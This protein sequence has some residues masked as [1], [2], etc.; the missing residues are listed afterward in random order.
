MISICL[1]TF[2]RSEFIAEAIHSIQRQS[3]QDWELIIVDDCST[4][5][6]AELLKWYIN[7]DKRIKVYWNDKNEGIAFS[8]NEAV[9]YAKG[10]YIAVMDSDDVMHPDRLK[11][12]LKA[13]KGK[14]FVY[15]SYIICDQEGHAL[16]GGL[17]MPPTKLTI[18]GVLDGFTPPHVT[19]LARKELFL[20]HPYLV[21]HRVNDDLKL[22]LDLVKGGYKY[23]RI[24]EPLMMVRYHDT[25]ISKEKAK[26][27]K[28]V[29]D[30]LKKEYL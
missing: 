22:Q 27:I 7:Q 4:D 12:E 11:K 2:N 1:P 3:Y 28:E 8:R 9:K 25:N 19:L 30:E 18:Q 21:S 15:S 20:A 26:E 14:D 29:T 16:Q 5:S 10:E 24:R 13:I 6:T 23:S 17:V